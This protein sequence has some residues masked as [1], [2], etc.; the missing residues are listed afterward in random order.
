M[1]FKSIV[2]AVCACLVV[3]SFNSSAVI[4][5]P[6]DFGPNAVIEDYENLGLLSRFSSPVMI[7][8]DTYTFNPYYN[9]LTYSDSVNC[10]SGYCIGLRSRSMRIQIDLS[11]TVNRA[12]IYTSS[13]PWIP[14]T[15]AVLDIDGN[16]IEETSIGVL[17]QSGHFFYGI[18]ATGNVIASVEFLVYT[19]TTMV[20]F[21]NFTT[22]TVVPIPAAV[23][24]FGS[25]LIG[26]IGF[27]RRKA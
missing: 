7:G 6:D 25:G 12:G 2:G 26:L 4:I 27:A 23:W 11:S 24:L 3:V 19:E 16:V 18:E 13:A 9:S 1:V 14:E 8:D 5:G 17:T 20:Y 10:V 21:D 15:F 22:E